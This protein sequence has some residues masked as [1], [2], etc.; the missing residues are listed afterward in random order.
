MET[1][2]YWAAGIGGRIRIP[3]SDRNN[4][5]LD[6]GYSSLGWRIFANI[7]EQF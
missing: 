6:L 2:N 5:R 4:L 3:P 7:G 1:E